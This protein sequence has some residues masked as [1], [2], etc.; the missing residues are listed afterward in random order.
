MMS[1]RLCTWHYCSEAA[2]FVLQ[3]G[4][5]GEP[6]AWRPDERPHLDTPSCHPHG[7]SRGR[8]MP[9]RLQQMAGIGVL[10]LVAGCVTG[11][12]LAA[13][14]P[15]PRPLPVL[16]SF[17]APPLPPEQRTPDDVMTPAPPREAMI[18]AGEPHPRGLA[19]L[20]AA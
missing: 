6:S 16:P 4:N 8:S 5:V 12:G 9:K 17:P 11:A 18:P 10:M 19:Q 7:L 13:D 1:R 20:D 2:D 15:Q 14:L 3:P